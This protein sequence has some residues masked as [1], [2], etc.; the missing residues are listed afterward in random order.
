MYGELRLDNGK[1]SILLIR[2]ISW[3]G[4]VVLGGGGGGPG[5]VGDENIKILQKARQNV[6]F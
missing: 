5:M 6:I 2:I 4:G 3:G 1:I